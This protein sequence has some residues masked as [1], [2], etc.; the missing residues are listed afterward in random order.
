[1]DGKSFAQNG[2]DANSSPVW[3][4]LYAERNNAA[5]RWHVNAE[6]ALLSQVQTGRLDTYILQH[7]RR[8]I[9][10]SS[11]LQAFFLLLFLPLLLPVVWNPQWK[12]AVCACRRSEST[13]D[14]VRLVLCFVTLRK[15]DFLAGEIFNTDSLI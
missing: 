14:R 4:G 5:G 10:I 3:M 11:I 15:S 2:M 8:E 9:G 6:A 13:G 1:M 12:R 7:V